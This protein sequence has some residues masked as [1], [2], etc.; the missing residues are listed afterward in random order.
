MSAAELVE[1][2]AVE[3]VEPL[4]NL[5][6][7]RTGVMAMDERRAALAEAGDIDGLAIGAAD[8]GDLVGDLQTVQRQARLDVARLL[9]ATFT[10]TGRPKKEIPHL[11]VVEVPGGNERKEWKHDKVLREVVMGVV[12]DPETGEVTD[13]GGPVKTAEAILA[14]LLE[15]CGTFGWRV[16]TYDRST[17]TWSGLRG[18]GIDPGDYCTEQE[19]ER[20]ATIPKRSS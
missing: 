7:I 18:L 13:H 17:D 11:G 20:I 3:V 14:T 8:L 5:M 15:V 9:Q 16:G 19:K 6:S 10:G 12:V 1:P 2:S 4:G